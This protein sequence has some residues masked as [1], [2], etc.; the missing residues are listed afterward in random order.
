MT[1]TR[2]SATPT[3]LYRFLVTVYGEL[4]ARKIFRSNGLPIP[5]TS[6][7]DRPQAA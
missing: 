5:G 4:T 3:V 7:V 2:Y 6:G 1:K